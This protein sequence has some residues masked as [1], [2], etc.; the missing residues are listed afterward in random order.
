[1]KKLS[2][3]SDSVMI[4][5]LIYNILPPLPPNLSRHNPGPPLATFPL[6]RMNRYHTYL[7]SYSLDHIFVFLSNAG[8]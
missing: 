8:Q 4:P 6:L 1:M 2:A 3:L 5:K 7:L